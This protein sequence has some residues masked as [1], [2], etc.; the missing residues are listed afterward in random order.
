[1]I[2][3]DGCQGQP[4]VA[5]LA[6]QTI[7]P[8]PAKLV[9][10]TAVCERCLRRACRAVGMDYPDEIPREPVPDIFEEE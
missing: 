7:N 10:R 9:A 4:A 6:V 1:M 5:W 8:L 2:E 3:C